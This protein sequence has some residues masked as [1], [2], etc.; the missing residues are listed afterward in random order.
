MFFIHVVLFGAGF[1]LREKLEHW[2]EKTG[3]EAHRPL[4]GRPP[5]HFIS[6]QHHSTKVATSGVL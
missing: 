3:V 6:Q 2:Q 1:M 4:H 5:K